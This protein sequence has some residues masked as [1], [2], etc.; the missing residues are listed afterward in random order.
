MEKETSKKSRKAVHNYNFIDQN[1][2]AVT[3]DLNSYVA[4]CSV[5]GNPKRF[6]HAYLANLINS[7]YDGNIDVF[8]QNYVS[9]EGRSEEVA[10]KRSADLQDRI[11]SLYDKIATLKS[12]QQELA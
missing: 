7:K 9:R 6:Y 4:V 11:D 3:V 12:K 5:T 10:A 2:T 1:G 8:E